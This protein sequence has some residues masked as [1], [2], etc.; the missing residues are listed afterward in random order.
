[1]YEDR[2]TGMLVPEQKYVKALN[3]TNSRSD[4]VTLTVKFVNDKVETIVLQP[5]EVRY[6]EGHIGPDSWTATD[7]IENVIIQSGENQ[8]ELSL[9]EPQGIVI[10]NVDL[11]GEKEIKTF[12]S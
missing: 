2:F 11:S 9:P 10:Y 5:N 8:I 4:H 6:V 12:I 7:P 3:F 1:M